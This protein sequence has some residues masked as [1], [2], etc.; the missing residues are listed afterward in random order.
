MGRQRKYFSEAEKLAANRQK[1]K[2]YYEK[3]KDSI[4]R[5]R[6]RKYA[7]IQQKR[8]E[9]A[10]KAQA[11]EQ[12]PVSKSKPPAAT[13][14][15]EVLRVYRRFNT[16]IKSD[17]IAHTEAIC[18]QFISNQ[19]MHE[20][21]ESVDKIEHFLGPISRYKNHIYMCSGVG[22]EWNKTVALAKLLEKTQSWLQEIELTAM[23]DLEFVE[24]NY[25]AK[26]F[27]FQKVSQ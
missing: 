5:R 4:N 26:S 7:R 14:L 2:K 1:S 11:V 23:E 8:I 6:R 16:F 19:D 12:E 27:E 22:P 9:T 25:N 13:W 21:S 20:L 18:L 17:P 10:R 24:R 15:D 3:C